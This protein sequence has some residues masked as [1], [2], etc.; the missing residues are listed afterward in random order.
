MVKNELLLNLIAITDDEK[1]SLR[2][3]SICE[4]FNFTYKILKSIDNLVENEKSNFIIVFFKNSGNNEISGHV[5]IVKYFNSNAFIIAVVPKELDAK[6]AE[7][8][9]K[10]GASII[11]LEKDLFISSKFEF[12]S[13]QMIKT[14]YIPIKVSELKTDRVIN[15]PLY[16][17]MPY[18]KKYIKYNQSDCLITKE[19]KKK[20][21]NKSNSEIYIHRNDLEKY[22]EYL[23]T[24]IDVSSEGVNARSRAIFLNLQK[25][26]NELIILLCDRGAPNSTFSEGKEILNNCL[27]ICD[28]LLLSI[29]S[30]EDPMDVINN[31]IEEDFGS[32][33]RIPSQMA[34]SGLLALNSNLDPRQVMLATLINNLG[35]ITLPYS[36]CK[37]IKEEKIGELDKNQLE[38]YYRLPILSINLVLSKKIPLAEEVKEIILHSHERMDKKGFPF[39]VDSELISEESQLVQFNEEL[40]YRCVIRMGKCRK[41]MKN[42]FKIMIDEHL[43]KGKYSPFFIHKMKA[44]IF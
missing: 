29:S 34:I 4:E 9:K 36:I 31:V 19:W 25:T 21:E 14:T 8:T 27:K 26:F 30:V 44:V 24:N 15:F 43:M 40:D 7:F 39:N 23:K 35:L 22:Y 11:L 16:Y 13:I 10:S 2:I 12:L 38:Q 1:N 28:D 37:K 41:L 5:Q 33:E 3:K 6:S 32:V 18:N 42:E 17:I 20:N